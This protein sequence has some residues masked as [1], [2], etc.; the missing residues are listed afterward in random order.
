MEEMFMRSKQ[1]KFQSFIFLMVLIVVTGFAGAANIYYVNSITGSD[2]YPG[3]ASQPFKTVQKGC[4]SMSNA[5]GD[6]LKI[7][8]GTYRETV[9]FYKYGT[10]ANPLT[11]EPNGT[12]SVIIKGSDVFTNWTFG[13]SITGGATYYTPVTYQFEQPNIGDPAASAYNSRVEMVFVDGVPYTQVLTLSA[14]TVGTFYV[15]ARWSGSNPPASDNLY[16]GLATDPANHTIEISTRQEGFAFQWPVY[17]SQNVTY[18]TVKGLTVMH[19]ACGQGATYR[20]TMALFIQGVNVTV[21]GC[22]ALYNNWEGIGASTTNCT[23][24]NCTANYNGN[25]GMGEGPQSTNFIHNTTNYNGWRFYPEGPNWGSG[26]MKW[27]GDHDVIRYNVFDGCISSH[28]QGPGIWFDWTAGSTIKNSLFEDNLAQGIKCEAMFRTYAGFV[29]YNN[30]VDTTRSCSNPSSGSEDGAGI[31]LYEASDCNVYNNTVVNNWYGIV[32]TGGSRPL[33]GPTGTAICSYNNFY[34][35][36]MANNTC[37]GL[38]LHTWDGSC[39]YDFTHQFNNNLYYGSSNNVIFYDTVSCGSA[40]AMT[41][42]QFNAIAA[43][44]PRYEISGIQADPKFLNAIADNYHLTSGSPAVNAGA[45]KGVT[46]DF[47]G[48]PRPLPAGGHTDIGAYEYARYCGTTKDY[49]A[50]DGDINLDCY[51]DFLD[52]SILASNYLSSSASADLTGDGIVDMKDLEEIAANWLAVAPFYNSAPFKA[53][54]PNPAN[55]AMNISIA[56]GLSWSPG[57]G[58]SSQAVYF[59]TVYPGTFQGNLAGAT[60]APGVLTPNTT[61]YWRIDETNVNGT[62][63]GDVWSFTT[64]A[65]PGQASSPDPCDTATSV[66]T[67]KILGW[68]AGSNTT[69]HNVYFGTAN[70]PAFIGNQSGTTYSP[71]SMAVNTTY[72]W[73]IDEVG[74]GGTTSGNVWSFT[75]AALAMPTKA[76]TPI[77]ANNAINQSITK[78]LSWTAGSNATSHNVYFSTTNPPAFIGNQTGTTYNPGTMSLGT[79]YYWRID[80]VG[81]GGTTTGDVWSFTTTSTAPPPGQAS[82]PDPAAGATGV[83]TT[84]TLGWTAGSYATSHDVYFG[85]TSPGTYMGNQTGTTYNPGTLAPNTTYY[86]RID[87]KNSSWTIAGNVW[88]FTT[89]S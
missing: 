7:E 81:T 80:E 78:T 38:Y 28:N 56:S 29:I 39:Q 48:N 4:N 21:D 33:T 36:I 42:A 2:S 30:I 79:K 31:L 86:W 43:A 75:T 44:N 64:A 49:F 15:P 65:V 51:V 19:V 71:G 74:P 10:S 61:Y 18:V 23:I 66:S 1:C 14:C 9:E 77:P 27:V 6:T 59:G 53:A 62:T 34:N 40:M 17:D 11:I 55:G 67:L 46:S 20:K 5:S 63:V 54:S 88:S 22:A 68:T 82:N 45:E 50:P 32:N 25:T 12:G 83:S 70:P 58:A 60:F 87:E 41:V 16:I 72:Y 84:K 73:R 37:Y 26:G 57:A 69:S 47:D 85:T 24:E 76:T 13:Q 3:T 52:F 35:N 89:G 8:P